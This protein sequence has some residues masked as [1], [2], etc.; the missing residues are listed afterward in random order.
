MK[1]KL[2][3]LSFINLDR[4]LLIELQSSHEI[5]TALTLD[6]CK[7]SSFNEQHFLHLILGQTCMTLTLELE[8]LFLEALNTF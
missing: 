3:N 6:R 2:E 1:N 7:L 4:Y 8:T 5:Q